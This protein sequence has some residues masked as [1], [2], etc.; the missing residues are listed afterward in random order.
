MTSTSRKPASRSP[1]R[2]R[3]IVRPIFAAL[4]ATGVIAPA[5]GATIPVTHGGDVGNTSTCTL[6]QAVAS[7]NLGAAVDSCVPTGPFGTN[8]IVDLTA[9]IGTIALGGTALP[10][11][12]SIAFS[13]PGPTALRI[14]GNGASRVFEIEDPEANVRFSDVTI[15]N[16]RSLGPGGCI[17]MLQT[18]SPDPIYFGTVTLE[19]A[20]VTGCVAAN[21][22]DAAPGPFPALG[23]G[24]GVFAYAV[25][26]LN[27]TISGN[28]AAMVG[29]GVVAGQVAM[30]QTLVTGNTTQGSLPESYSVYGKYLGLL[31]GGGIASTGAAYLVQS[32]V[33][34][35][36][37]RAISVD[38]TD[39]DTPLTVRLGTGGGI[40]VA[41][42]YSVEDDDENEFGLAGAKA[43]VAGARPVLPF[44]PTR[45][46]AAQWR[47]K[48]AQHFRASTA[49]AKAAIRPKALELP[50]GGLLLVDSTVSGNRVV[51]ASGRPA[52]PVIAK[53]AGGGAAFLSL[54]D[55]SGIVNSTISGNSLPS[56]N[57][58]DASQVSGSD[59]PSYRASCGAAFIGDSA[60][61]L[62]STI[63]GN[64]GNTAAHFKY[65]VPIPTTFTATAAS[66]KVSALAKD[67]RVSAAL[68]R[69][70]EARATEA[71][72]KATSGPVMT[73]SIV[74][75][76]GVAIDVGC[77]VTCTID[78]SNNLVRTQQTTVTFLN[79]TLAA[80]PSLG[81]LADNGGPVAGAPGVLG[82][83]VVR[84]HGLYSNSPAIDQ[85]ANP[86]LLEYD[87]RGP[88]F[89]RTTGADTDIGAF[90]G[91]IGPPPPPTAVA[92]PVL[93]P[94]MLGALSALLGLLGFARARRRG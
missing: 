80:F 73:S 75:T 55:P 67:P 72:A 25:E 82:T 47:S 19:R 41:G 11:Q 38:S 28:T 66:A 83:S 17:A 76:N 64:S 15:A 62:N 29:G 88:G 10:L 78:G 14:S 58:C 43:T 48:A 42:K 50:L 18:Y 22:P 34:N 57:G 51:P 91:D 23:A 65:G 74:S 3:F 30:F 56:G 63:T 16:G 35:N 87:Q 52:N 77:T 79:P 44:Q 12:R 81:P 21:A 32:T 5:Q 26:A 86:S 7:I 94:W 13:G 49:G 8:D 20:V 46:K 27:S 93:G 90:E 45:A 33:S 2:A 24:G 39:G 4:V 71:R 9:Q 92:V 53:Y 68:K 37:V 31:G 1:A 61:V 36:S 54:T 40:S 70:G 69:F 84:T 59:Q 85:G 60:V 6:R 89:A